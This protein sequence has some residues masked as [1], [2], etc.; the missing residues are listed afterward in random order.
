MKAWSKGQSDGTLL[1]DLERHIPID[2][3]QDA[4]ADSFAAWLKNHPF[5]EL[6]SRDRGTTLLMEPTGEP[7][8]RFRL[9]IAGMC[10]TIWP[11][12]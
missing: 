10:F 4:S 9:P 5:V 2:L 6:I 12:H 7:H 8:K 1:V 3:L 11:K